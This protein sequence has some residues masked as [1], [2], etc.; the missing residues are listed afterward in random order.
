M[1]PDENR[2]MGV[3]IGEK[4]NRM[5][6]PVRFLL[7]QGGFSSVDAPGGLFW[8]PVADGA[9]IDAICDTVRQGPDRKVDVLPFHINDS[10]FANATVAA[11][12]EIAR[13]LGENA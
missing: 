4:L 5:E 10:A 1:A 6:G 8:D 9:F 3:W 2:R 7:P 12:R 11:F 13:S